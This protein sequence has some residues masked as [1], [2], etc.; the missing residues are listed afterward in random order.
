MNGLHLWSESQFTVSYWQYV[1]YRNDI[2]L[3]SATTNTFGYS[4]SKPCQVYALL[5]LHLHQRNV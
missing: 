4:C 3:E 1:Y 5:L 2:V